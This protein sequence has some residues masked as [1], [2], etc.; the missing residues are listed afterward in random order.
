[1]PVTY[2]VDWLP[3]EGDFEVPGGTITFTVDIGAPG[4]A[5]V[6]VPTGGTTGQVLAKASA[7][8]YDTGWVNQ[9]GATLSDTTALGTLTAVTSPLFLLG[10]NSAGTFV[11]RVTPGSGTGGGLSLLLAA[12]RAAVLALLGTGTPGSGTFLTGTGWGN[13]LSGGLTLGGAL[14][15]QD[16]DIFAGGGVVSASAFVG[17]FDGDGSLLTGLNG[18]E[19]TSGTVAPSRLGSGTPGVGNFLRGDGSWQT[20]S[21]S[22]GGS[23]GQVQFNDGG[24]FG[25]DSG[26]TYNSTTDTLTVGG[27]YLTSNTHVGVGSSLTFTTGTGHVALG[28]SLTC[29]SSDDS[30]NFGISNSVT[31]RVSG[32]FGRGCTVSGDPQNFA[33]GNSCSA[34]AGVGSGG[35]AFAAGTTCAASAFRSLA[36]G[37]ETTAAH[38]AMGLGEFANTDAAGDVVF[39]LAGTPPFFKAKSNSTTT[40]G[41]LVAGVRTGWQ[42]QTDAT[43]LGFAEVGAYSLATF[44]A[45]LRV[46][47]NSGGVRLGHFGVPAVSRRSGNVAAGLVSLGLFSQAD[48]PFIDA[49]IYGG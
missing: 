18:S 1:M 21:A 28:R 44:Q 42:D 43:R 14:D 10:A 38:R 45:G 39:G 48:D 3:G 49:L 24:A 29:N 2:Y 46:E 5:G 33:L 30:F 41:R 4:A 20:V 17:T 26:F 19:I 23:S 47:A 15:T 9:A 36:L 32:A 6:G 31:A 8:N 11:R 40:N 27:F 12:D 22:P 37:W 16:N 7:A 25:G 35:Q 34:T 13:E